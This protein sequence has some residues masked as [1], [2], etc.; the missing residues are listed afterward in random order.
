MKKEKEQKTHGKKS[1]EESL[2]GLI[3]HK[4]F[5]DSAPLDCN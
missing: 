3:Y 1:S 5:L 2:Q 4:S